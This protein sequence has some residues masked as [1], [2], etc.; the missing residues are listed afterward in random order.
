MKTRKYLYFFGALLATSSVFAQVFTGTNAP[1]AGQ[2]FS[3]SV[4]PGVTNL[5]L[6]VPGSAAGYSSIYLR[7]GSAPDRVVY[8]FSSQLLARTNGIYLEQPELTQGTYWVRVETPAT[9]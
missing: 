7:K 3:F 2:N 5:A 1:G 6:T 8:D 9:S 4:G